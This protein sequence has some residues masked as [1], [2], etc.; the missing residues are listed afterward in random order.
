MLSLN[1]CYCMTACVLHALS[2]SFST[3]LQDFVALIVEK[4]L[5]GPTGKHCMAGP[6][7][8]GCG[9]VP[10][11][12]GKAAVANDKLCSTLCRSLGQFELKL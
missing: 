6:G 12:E 4:H 1:A 5:Q 3:C 8:S 9:T 7:R 2:F 11:A 10:Q